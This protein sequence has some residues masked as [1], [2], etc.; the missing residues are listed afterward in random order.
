MEKGLQFRKGAH[1]R[2]QVIL[3]ST[4]PSKFGKG[5][6]GRSRSRSRSPPTHVELPPTTDVTLRG[7]LDEYHGRRTS[8]Q[9]RQEEELRNLA[10]MHSQERAD[11]A[12]RFEGRIMSILQRDH[13][14]FKGAILRLNH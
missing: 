13:Q 1:W 10:S 12:A 11:M 8:L 4:F 2:E 6:K 14:G 7:I 9:E 5:K 3:P